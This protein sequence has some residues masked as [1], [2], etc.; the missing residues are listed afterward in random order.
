M[1]QFKPGDVVVH[2]ADRH[3]RM[4]VVSPK[5][6]EVVCATGEIRHFD[7][8]GAGTGWP[9]SV[10]VR[11][12]FHPFELEPYTAS[13]DAKC[14]GQ[15]ADCVSPCFAGENGRSD[16]WDDADDWDEYDW[17]TADDQYDTEMNTVAD[18]GDDGVYELS[19]SYLLSLTAE[20]LERDG[21]PKLAGAVDHIRDKHAKGDDSGKAVL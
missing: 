15:P 13:A 3:R 8:V 18:D 6:T 10:A 2:K 20:R 4:V 9:H 19:T 7:N 11:V 12:T 14:C 16:E 5:E 1:S 17:T 21:F